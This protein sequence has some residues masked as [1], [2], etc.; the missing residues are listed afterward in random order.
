[1]VCSDF[2]LVVVVVMR[3]VFSGVVSGYFFSYKSY[4]MIISFP[5]LRKTR[6]VDSSFPEQGWGTF[7][8]TI[9]M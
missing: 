5:L 8:N 9:G 1:M 2:G 3:T 6:A 7:V 4:D